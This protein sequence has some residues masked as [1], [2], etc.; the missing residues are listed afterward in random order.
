MDATNG[1]LSSLL[2][3]QSVVPAPY[4]LDEVSLQLVW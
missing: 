3:P 1:G 4:N 2:E